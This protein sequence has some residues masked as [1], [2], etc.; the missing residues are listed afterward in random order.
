LI[1]S[2]KAVPM[3]IVMDCFNI[4]LMA[5]TKVQ[6]RMQLKNWIK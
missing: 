5:K 4:V 3:I 6:E 1:A 2:G